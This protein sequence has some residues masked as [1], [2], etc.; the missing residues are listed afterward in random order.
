MK[1]LNV[2]KLRGY[3]MKRQNFTLIELL[4]V[5]AIIA[6]LA[7]M[8]LPAL[9]KARGRAQAAGCI[10]NLKQ[11]GVIHNFYTDDN[12]GFYAPSCF[13]TAP[14]S[15]YGQWFYMNRVGYL[16]EGGKKSLCCPTLKVYPMRETGSPD[17]M[18]YPPNSHLFPMLDSSNNYIPDSKVNAPAWPKNSRIKQPSARLAVTEGYVTWSGYPQVRRWDCLSEV[19][20][21]WGGTLDNNFIHD[22]GINML[23]ADGHAA[24][25]KT[26]NLVQNQSFTLW[27]VDHW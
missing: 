9:N 3:Q 22:Q 14:A 2:F 20:N 12:N 1:N 10:N 26:N 15:Q 7:S 18:S 13:Y 25:Y 21:P 4:V 6:I 8:L 5:I 23:Y 24:W 16:K 19:H 17:A 27:G 11:L